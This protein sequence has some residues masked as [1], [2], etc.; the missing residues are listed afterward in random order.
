MSGDE[1]QNQKRLNFIATKTATKTVLNDAD[2]ELDKI[3]AMPG[4]KV[5]IQFPVNRFKPIGLFQSDFEPNK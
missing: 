3:I 4:I 5:G 1:T 2:K